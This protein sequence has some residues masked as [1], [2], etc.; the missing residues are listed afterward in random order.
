MPSQSY[1]QLLV[2]LI[3]ELFRET[4]T[5]GY[6]ELEAVSL[7]S[8]LTKSLRER[9]EGIVS[10]EFERIFSTPQ[11]DASRLDADALQNLREVLLDAMVIRKAEVEEAIEKSA[12]S[13]TG[14]WSTDPLDLRALE[15]DPRGFSIMIFERAREL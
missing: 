10:T 14:G 8:A 7:P 15:T 12:N 13:F 3:N 6:R 9:S 11:F 1:N 5:A 4:G 2:Q